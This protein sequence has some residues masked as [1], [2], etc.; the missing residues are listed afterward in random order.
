MKAVLSALYSACVYAFF[1]A[2]FLYAIAFVEGIFV[3][4][5]ID[6]GTPGALLPSLVIDA[7]LLGLFAVQH[8]VMARPAFKRA[9][10][11][12]LPMDCE[13]STFVLFASLALAL[14]IWQW[15]PMPEIVWSVDNRL[16]AMAILAVSWAGCWPMLLVSTF[17][18]SHFHLFGLTQ[19]FGR[20]LR[21]QEP[22]LDVRDAALLSLAPPPRSTPASSWRSR[23]A[24]LAMS[25]GHLF[26]ADRDH[27]IHLHRY[28]VRGARPPRG[29]RRGATSATAKSV[30]MLWPKLRTAGRV[31][32]GPRPLSF[33]APSGASDMQQPSYQDLL[34]TSQQ[35]NWRIDDIIGGDK[36]LDFSGAVPAGGVRA[37][38]GTHL[39]L[40]GGTADAQPHSIPRLP[41]HVRA[42]R[43]VHRAI[44]LGAGG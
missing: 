25:L 23:A 36:R 1:L 27:G 8:T 40:P 21:R 17:L 31:P 26:F 10:T 24:P 19:G 37:D 42:R 2:T 29:L 3:P 14:V 15:R 34:E 22:D 18:I 12:I 28:L 32:N 30:G 11:R 44:H 13:R 39:P 9:W 33:S 4:K 7:A 43:A 41:G 35:V 5:A 20:L 6:S 16:A 38:G